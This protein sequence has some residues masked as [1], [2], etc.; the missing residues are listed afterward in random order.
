MKLA[1][2]TSF[3]VPS[4]EVVSALAVVRMEVIETL[5]SVTT[6]LVLR[7]RVTLLKRIENKYTYNSSISTYKSSTNY[8]LSVLSIVFE[9]AKSFKIVTVSRD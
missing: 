6:G 8:G 5:G 2:L 9:N 4:A 1:Q 3:A 7:A